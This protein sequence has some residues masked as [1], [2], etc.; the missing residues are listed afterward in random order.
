MI[1]EGQESKERER[2]SK[3][4]FLAHFD[5]QRRQKTEIQV[6]AKQE[7]CQNYKGTATQKNRYNQERINLLRDSTILVLV[8]KV[9]KF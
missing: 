4:L 1:G 9:R 5:F 6:A 7:V 8:G 3:E 2:V